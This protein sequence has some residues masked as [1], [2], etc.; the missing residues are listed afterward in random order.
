[1]KV[2]SL[3]IAIPAYNEEFSIQRVI[4]DAQ[5]I[6]HTLTNKLEILLVDDGST[7]STLAIMK[8][9]AKKDRKI[10]IIQHKKNKGFSGAIHS[11]YRNASSKWV[12]LVPADGQISMDILPSFIQQTQKA[13]I[14][15]G[16]RT[17]NPEPFSRKVNS[18]VFH[19]LFRTLFGVK[20][21]EISTAILWK[22]SVLDAL[23]ISAVDRSALIQPE[24][25]YKAWKAQYS[26]AQVGFPYNIRQGGKAKGT[27][28]KMIL[29]TMVEL[30][31]LRFFSKN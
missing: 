18:W 21:H 30:F 7:D 4:L 29:M 28:P 10:H 12:F 6:G 31:R 2:S 20:L 26:F 11:C 17:T 3:T 13:D 1:M 8:S 24:L 5:K 14:V 15:V 23:N 27:D 16:Y 25:I 9:A 22:K 19:L